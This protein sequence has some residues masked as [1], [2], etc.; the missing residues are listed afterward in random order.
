MSP[1]SPRC[2]LSMPLIEILMSTPLLRCFLSMPVIQVLISA[3]PHNC[4]WPRLTCSCDVS[5]LSDVSFVDVNVF[6]ESAADAL[7]AI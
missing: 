5:S 7:G 1:F 4:R 3:P 6:F 2:V